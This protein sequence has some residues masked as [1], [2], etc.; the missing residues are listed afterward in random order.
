MPDTQRWWQ[1]NAH[2]EKNASIRWVHKAPCLKWRFWPTKI[3][4]DCLNQQKLYQICE[5]TE[6]C[7]QEILASPNGNLPR[8]SRG[9]N[10]FFFLQDPGNFG[11]GSMY[12]IFLYF[13]PQNYVFLPL[14]DSEEIGGW[15]WTIRLATGNQNSI[16]FS[17]KQ[18][19]SAQ[20][21]RVASRSK[22]FSIQTTYIRIKSGAHKMT[23]GGLRQTS[24]C[25]LVNNR[26][27]LS[28]L[29]NKISMITSP[30]PFF[31]DNEV[32]GNRPQNDYWKS[33]EDKPDCLSRTLQR[34]QQRVSWVSRTTLIFF[35]WPYEHWKAAY[36]LSFL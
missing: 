34:F 24:L 10:T 17:P 33:N 20:F 25:H 8:K 29:F 3:E 16:Y 1:R 12:F 2:G 22:V 21:Q 27:V 18:R 13:E 6:K 32:T 26:G 30:S 9:E 31:P 11:R 7:L 15:S 4:E 28:R 35:S 14:S 23:R 36:I 19:I 5:K